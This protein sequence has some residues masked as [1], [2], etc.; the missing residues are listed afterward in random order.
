MAND[1]NTNARNDSPP[2]VPMPMNPVNPLKRQFRGPR[3]FTETQMNDNGSG[4][5]GLN[6]PAVNG[7]SVP[8]GSSFWSYAEDTNDRTNAT[9]AGEPMMDNNSPSRAENQD[10]NENDKSQ[11]M[12][13]A[14]KSLPE[15]ALRGLVQ[16]YNAV[17]KS[18]GDIGR[19]FDHI[20]A[21]GVFAVMVVAWTVEQ[22][23]R[24]MERGETEIQIA[25]RNRPRHGM[26][27]SL[28]RIAK[29]L[30]SLIERRRIAFADRR[31]SRIASHDTTSL[32]AVGRPRESIWGRAQAI[33]QEAL[34]SVSASTTRPTFKQALEIVIRARIGQQKTVP[35]RVVQNRKGR[36]SARQKRVARQ[37][38]RSLSPGVS[39]TRRNT[40]GNEPSN[41]TPIFSYRQ[42]GA[43][44]L[45]AQPLISGKSYKR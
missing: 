44:A 4:T 29:A 3:P 18:P 17:P 7:E 30:R 1:A 36:A 19:I 16:A 28:K 42:A 43:A 11:G 22:A 38:T 12:D 23:I 13:G 34:A 32:R 5:P 6:E 35:L 2:G 9:S 24:G 40:P 10:A 26:R 31:R 41:G 20:A 21:W 27:S 37:N 33:W 39:Q 14:P 45:A 25:K 15:R 8:S